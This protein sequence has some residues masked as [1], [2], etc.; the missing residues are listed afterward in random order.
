MENESSL[1]LNEKADDFFFN[2]TWFVS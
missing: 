2:N 1:F